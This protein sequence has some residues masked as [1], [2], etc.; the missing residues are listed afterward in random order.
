MVKILIQTVKTAILTDNENDRS[1]HINIPSHTSYSWQKH[2]R[3]MRHTMQCNKHEIFCCEVDRMERQRQD[4]TGWSRRD[5]LSKEGRQVEW[6]SQFHIR[7]LQAPKP[8]LW[9]RL[10][11]EGHCTLSFKVK[12]STR[13]QVCHPESWKIQV[14][15]TLWLSLPNCYSVIFYLSTNVLFFFFNQFLYQNLKGTCKSPFWGK[16]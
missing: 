1:K 16:T 13:A 12:H 14:I 9:G 10:R 7:T 8:S 6:W 4:I 5:W 11:L 15:F 3:Q 2:K